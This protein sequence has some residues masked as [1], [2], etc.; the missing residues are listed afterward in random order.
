ML[1]AVGKIV[2]PH[3]IHGE[4]VVEVRT[5]EPALRF[6]PGSVLVTDPG[7]ALFGGSGPASVPEGVWRPPPN[8][9]V[10]AMRP[11]QGRLLVQ[12][13][14][15]ADRNVAEALRRVVLCVESEEL[16]PTTDPDEFHDHQLMGLAVVDGGGAP[17]GEVVRIDHAPAAD[18][19]VV[20]RPDGREALVPFVK[21]IVPD[22]DLAARRVVVTPPEGLFEL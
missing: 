8:L 21:A 10:A 15:V 19:L 11:H 16:P 5:D 3:G 9:T 1:L 2:R 13:E 7:G 14:G 6:A 22:V 17:I 4:V 18:L 20:R 12:F